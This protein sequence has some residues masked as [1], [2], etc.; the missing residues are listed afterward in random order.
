MVKTS[1]NQ[2]LIKEIDAGIKEVSVSCSVEKAHLSICGTN[3]KVRTVLTKGR[4]Y[5]GE[6]YI[7]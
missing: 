1:A 5:N 2:D 7:I 4:F 3:N 6:S